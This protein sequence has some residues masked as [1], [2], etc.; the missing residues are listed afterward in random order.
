MNKN[1][2]F[3]TITGADLVTDTQAV[4]GP[5][6]RLFKASASG[7]DG[8]DYVKWIA[9]Y[10]DSHAVSGIKIW[11][12]G[13]ANSMV[14][15]PLLLGKATGTET[16]FRIAGRPIESCTL[17]K[18]NFDGGRLGGIS[19]LL[20]DGSQFQAGHLQ[21][22]AVQLKIGR[23]IN[24]TTLVGLYGREGDNIDNL[25][26]VLN[27]PIV[28]W[29]LSDVQYDL[30]PTTRSNLKV[31]ALDSVTLISDSDI[32][33]NSSITRSRSVTAS[34]SWSHN[35]GAKIGLTTAISTGI[36][37][38]ADGKVEVS[39]EA[40]YGFTWGEGL[41]TSD[42]FEYTA[43]ATVPPH[44]AVEAEVLVTQTQFDLTY[45]ATAKATY[46]SGYSQTGSVSGTYEGIHAH[47][48]QIKYTTPHQLTSRPRLKLAA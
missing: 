8:Q 33:Q 37:F 26:L 9:V 41:E 43:T 46:A 10:Y 13:G 36:P 22:E 2:M 16:K 48:V 39:V 7:R 42:T 25:G 5:G 21:G 15:A 28:G 34:N 11:Y 47:D 19:L 38:I 14:S 40:S 20:E 3:S 23:S 44:A 12:N 1:Q 18:S 4:G 29:D 45:T 30:T 35:V 17:Y 27:D 31:E 6:G 32:A 24:G